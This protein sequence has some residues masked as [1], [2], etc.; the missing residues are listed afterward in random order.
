MGEEVR[1]GEAGRDRP[2]LVGPGG[3]G[4]IPVL[5]TLPFNAG[6]VGSIPGQGAGPRSQ[7]TNT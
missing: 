7:K 1:G 3:T 2:Y 5:D 4:V 6:S